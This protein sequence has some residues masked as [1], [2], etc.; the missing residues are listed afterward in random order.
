MPQQDEPLAQDWHSAVER[1]EETPSSVARARTAEPGRGRDAAAPE[2]FP[3]RGWRDILW[4]VFW[5]VPQDRVLPTAGSVAFFVLLAVFPGLATLVSLYGLFADPGGIRGQ[6]VLLHGV[7][8]EGVLAL[9][10]DE[11]A[12]VA[13]QRGE[14]LGL[15]FLISSAVAL[16]SANSGAAAL[17]DALNVVYK[18]REK[19]SLARF[20]A[21][22]FLFTLGATCFA[23]VAA[24][25]V[26]V[27][28]LA[29]GLLGLTTSAERVI[30]A[31]RWPLLLLAV[32]LCLALVY[33]FGP[34]RRP[35]KWRWVSWGSV[36]AAAL[37]VG[38]SVLYSWYV[39]SF[40]S[41]SR[42]YGALGAGVGFMTWIWLSIVVV[43]VGAELNA[44]ME[45]QT[46]VDTTRG[47]PRPLGVRGAVVADT[48]GEAQS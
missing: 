21:T 47:R 32:V 11:L 27:L 19:R 46:A 17:F 25:A 3:A 4:R 34:S 45:R 42:I 41:Y 40:D 22:T 24:G 36:V 23:I 35:A 43:L 38:V 37:L 29:L 15:A 26:V 44:E 14:A 10:G 13:S 48:V 16:W 30:S 12:R 39:V 8:P 28:P 18:E 2:D 33:R 20:Y 31:V 7:V 1:T 6:L 5:S 9:V